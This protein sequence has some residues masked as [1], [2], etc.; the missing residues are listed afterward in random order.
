MLFQLKSFVINQSPQRI[1]PSPILAAMFPL[2][3]GTAPRS[4][5]CASTQ[6]TCPTVVLLISRAISNLQTSDLLPLGSLPNLSDFSLYG[7]SVSVSDLSNNSALRQISLSGVQLG[8]AQFLA[9]VPNLTSLSLFNLADYSFA[10]QATTAR[11]LFIVCGPAGGTLPDFTPLRNNLAHLQIFGSLASPL[12]DS[13]F[14]LT[15]LKT[16]TLDAL[17]T[18]FTSLSPAIAN[19]QQLESLTIRASYSLKGSLPPLRV[20]PNL[21]RIELFALGFTEGPDLSGCLLLESIEVSN[22]PYLLTFPSVQSPGTPSLKYIKITSMALN[23]PFEMP[24]FNATS[25]EEIIVT[26]SWVNTTIPVD[27]FNPRL[28]TINLNFLLEAVGAVPPELALATG[29]ESLT[30]TSVPGLTGEVAAPPGGFPNLTMVEISGTG[31]TGLS[32]NFSGSPIRSLYALLWSA[33]VARVSYHHSLS[34]E[35]SFN[36]L[37]ARF[38]QVILELPL[39][40]S[41]IYQSPLGAAEPLPDLGRL[42][43]LQALELSGS[44]VGAFPANI[45]G[46]T[47]LSVS[48]TMISGF[49]TAAQFGLLR[50]LTW[51]L[52]DLSGL[53][54]PTSLPGDSCALVSIR[55]NS[56]RLS[57]PVPPV[58]NLCK[59][60]QLV[61]LSRNMLGP[62]V[63]RSILDLPKLQTLSLN[64]NN[65]SSIEVFR[66]RRSLSLAD[67]PINLSNNSFSGPVT[68]E[69]V[70]TISTAFTRWYLTGN[71]LECPRAAIGDALALWNKT[72]AIQSLVCVP[73]SPK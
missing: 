38:P 2:V 61:D 50:D 65:F 22:F 59:D 28:R 30:I 15:S 41:L 53:V 8:A 67:M 18:N 25:I 52:N 35:L 60:L 69:F 23:V 4:R 48:Q 39:L 62:V 49:P 44:F 26:T 19:L 9:T 71:S 5:H 55:V 47:S 57:G 12:P 70:E 3:R 42:S 10:S 64:D 40:T 11:S 34:S 63:P 33:A 68:P 45:S 51:S 31:I 21:K 58:L 14:N 72:M 32:A 7:G 16:L 37:S 20:F 27:A 73:L 29:L 36:A 46:L 13:I 1:W 43:E 24:I 66:G 17:G 56:M 54:F 6:T